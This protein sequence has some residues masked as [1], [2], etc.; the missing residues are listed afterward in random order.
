MSDVPARPRVFSGIQPTADSFHLGN[1]LGAVR[2][3]VALQDS[4]DAFYCVVDLHAITAGHDPKVLKQ[5]TRVAAAQLLAVGHR[6]GAQ[7]PLRPVPGGRALPAGLGAR[8][9]SPASAR[10]A[11]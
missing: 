11:G 3:W 7:H 9:A 8:A 10:P 4:H 1:Y 6:P 2:H 5:R